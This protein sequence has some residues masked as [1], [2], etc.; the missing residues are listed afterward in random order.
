MDID[1]RTDQDTDLT[2][3]IVSITIPDRVFSGGKV[4]VVEETGKKATVEMPLGRKGVGSKVKQ[5]TLADSAGRQSVVLLDPACDV[6]SDGEARIILAD[7]RLKTNEP[8]RVTLTVDLPAELT[9]Y[10]GAGNV[11]DEPGLDQWYVFRPS[12]DYDKPSEIDLTG[13]L[14]APAGK[15]GRIVRQDDNLI[16]DGQPIKL[17]GLNVC[18][19]SCAPEKELADRR[20]KF[21][22]KYGINTVRLH[23]YADGPGWAGIQSQD[24]FV[25]FDSES[26]DRM[27]YFVAQLK[28]RGIYVLLSS[29]FGVKLGPKDRKYVP[30]MDE[31]GKGRNRVSTGHGSVFLSRELQDLQIRQI[32][33]ILEH[34]SPYTGLTYAEDPA[35][36]TT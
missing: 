21:Y 11:P 19:S 30:Y 6:A 16:Y 5:F 3:V 34:R 35:I 22:A 24:S 15:R 18:Y 29:T 9:Y 31:F 4:L 7:R 8:R 33:K 27:D 20:A 10:A 2:Y 28:K 32:V 12:Q 1:L 14:D 36:G 26:L 23:K 13:W 25:E 17:W